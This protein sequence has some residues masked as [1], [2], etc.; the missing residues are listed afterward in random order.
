MPELNWASPGITNCNHEDEITVVSAHLLHI[1]TPPH[2][3]WSWKGRWEGGFPLIFLAL[4]SESHWAM[5][6]KYQQLRQNVHCKMVA[7]CKGG[8][9]YPQ[10]YWFLLGKSLSS[11]WVWGVMPTGCSGDKRAAKLTKVW[12]KLTPTSGP[13]LTFCQRCLQHNL[14]LAF[15]MFWGFLGADFYMCDILY[16]RN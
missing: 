13:E 5:G 8:W 1:D 2:I 12:V 3:A 15:Y 7:G 10:I 14:G 16:K 11:V 6:A 9:L 4:N